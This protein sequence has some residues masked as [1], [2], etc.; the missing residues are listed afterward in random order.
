MNVATIPT[1]STGTSIHDGFYTVVGYHA[2]YTFR[3]VTNDADAAFAPGK[4]VISY[5]VGPC[6]ESDYMA[7]GFVVNGRLIVWKRFQQGYERIQ[8]AARFLIAGNHA[9]HGKAYAL[10]S[11][12]C[13]ICNRT[14]TTPESIAAGIGPTCAGKVA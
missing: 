9:N 11:G 2:H 5:L 7:F 8:A 1:T 13:Y 10:Q 4:Q 14:L 3:L 6:N 12:R